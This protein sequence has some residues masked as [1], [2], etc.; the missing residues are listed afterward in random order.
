L[1]D[2][3]PCAADENTAAEVRAALDLLA[4][5]DGKPAKDLTTALKDKDER[6][7]TTAA[8]IL[9]AHGKQESKKVGQRELTPGLKISMKRVE[10]QDGKKMVDWE[11]REIVFFNRLENRIF[12]K[13]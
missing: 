3:L 4:F 13:P 8:A 12:A 2:Y 1:L 9:E 6:V 7:R 10:L 5:P 11:I